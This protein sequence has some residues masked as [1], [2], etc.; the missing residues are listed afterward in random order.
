MLRSL[1]APLPLSGVSA[2]IPS[3]VPFLERGGFPCHLSRVPVD[4]RGRVPGLSQHK[5]AT[6]FHYRE[7]LPAGREPGGRLT[8]QHTSAKGFRW[9]LPGPGVGINNYQLINTDKATRVKLLSY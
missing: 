2:R 6:E 9:Q 7:K 5:I 4:H 1:P 8:P 3:P